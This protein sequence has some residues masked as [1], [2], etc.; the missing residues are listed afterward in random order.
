MFPH[1]ALTS[2]AIRSSWRLLMMPVCK[3]RFALG[4][5]IGAELP[6]DIQII[7]I[8]TPHVYDFSEELSSDAQH[9]VSLAIREVISIL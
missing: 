8:E 9:A 6:I 4:K 1:S 2:S 5:E 7:A 3:K